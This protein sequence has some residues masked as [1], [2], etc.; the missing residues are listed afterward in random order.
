MA[1]EER[2]RRTAGERKVTKSLG[3]IAG[4]HRSRVRA[5]AVGG[6]AREG[7]RPW[8][9]S[10]HTR[11]SAADALPCQAWPT[12]KLRPAHEPHLRLMGKLI[13]NAGFIEENWVLGRSSRD[14]G[15]NACLSQP[16]PIHL[17]TETQD[18]VLFLS[19]MFCCSG[20]ITHRAVHRILVL[21]CKLN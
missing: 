3:G 5:P 12:L 17:V 18:T 1:L 14:D 9:C 2:G 21:P 11:S 7:R 19:S 15:R 4:V 10:P 8:S 16:S 6:R 13:F 20:S